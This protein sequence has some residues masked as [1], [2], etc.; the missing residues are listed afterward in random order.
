V[1]SDRTANPGLWVRSERASPDQ[2]DGNDRVGGNDGRWLG[3]RGE[4]WQH[5]GDAACGHHDPTHAPQTRS[6]PCVH[7]LFCVH[8]EGRF[9]S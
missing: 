5:R 6:T 1:V 2:M 7:R 9:S 8:R 3:S 4:R